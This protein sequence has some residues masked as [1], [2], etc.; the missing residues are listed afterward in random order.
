MAER[1]GATLRIVCT[2]GVASAQVCAQTLTLSL[3]DS[4]QRLV[5]EEQ[6]DFSYSS[7]AY[8]VVRANVE[9]RRR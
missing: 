3:D 9:A 2:C 5:G 7:P 4:G 8:C 6:F 1:Q